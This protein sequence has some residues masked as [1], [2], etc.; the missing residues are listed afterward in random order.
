[1]QGYIRCCDKWKDEQVSVFSL[2]GG[3]TLILYML[4]SSTISW[5]SSYH[6]MCV[7]LSTLQGRE[8][9]CID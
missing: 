9:E 7:K 4:D 5:N 1:M 8:R 3:N 2:Q 6:V